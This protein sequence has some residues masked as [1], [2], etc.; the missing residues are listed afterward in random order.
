MQYLN[1]S[2]MVSTGSSKLHSCRANSVPVEEINGVP[3]EIT[4]DTPMKCKICG[5]VWIIDN[6]GKWKEI[7]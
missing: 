2:F 6:E 3:T 1:K 7:R 5:T 4:S